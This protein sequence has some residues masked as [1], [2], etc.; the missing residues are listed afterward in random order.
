[1]S[2]LCVPCFNS[3]E[4]SVCISWLKM[5]SV[6][7]DKEEGKNEEIKMIFCSLTVYLG[8]RWH[9]W[10]LASLQQI[11]FDSDKKSWSYIGVKSSLI[12]SCQYAH[13]VVR[14]P[15][16][17]LRCVLIV[18]IAN[19]VLLILLTITIIPKALTR[20][21]WNFKL[22]AHWLFTLDNKEVIN[23]HVDT[24]RKFL[25]VQVQRALY[26]TKSS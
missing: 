20:Y 21:S 10:L 24:Y 9:N 22:L 3:I 8:I 11:W 6:W 14:R 19:M 4:T 16:N 13:G 26:R 18:I 25:K 7:K 2:P 5:Q 1:M 17:R 23:I 15:H 12:P